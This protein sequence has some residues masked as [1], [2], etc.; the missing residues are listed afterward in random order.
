MRAGVAVV[1]ALALLGVGCGNRDYGPGDNPPQVTDVTGVNFG[2]VC[3]QSGC[4]VT[5]L[6]ATPAPDPCDTGQP[7]YG[8][9]WGR[10]FE[11]CSVCY[12]SD[13]SVQWSSTPGQCRMIACLTSADCPVMFENSP[14]DVYECVHGLCENADVGRYPRDPLQR[15]DAEELCF[16]QLPRAQTATSSAPAAVAVE[17]ELD[18][19]CAGTDPMSTC[20]L[21][22]DCRSP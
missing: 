12:P 3:I 17:T 7:G 16:A 15:V 9:A 22:G 14:P 21:P 1:G 13:A 11:V 10:F 18:A 4:G 20:T 6:G 2:W 19:S 5:R 8:Y